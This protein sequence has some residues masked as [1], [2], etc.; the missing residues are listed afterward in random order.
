MI[1]SRI[2]IYVVST[3]KEW[4][5]NRSSVIFFLLTHSSTQWRKSS[6]SSLHVSFV[7]GLLLTLS[8]H[9]CKRCLS[10]SHAWSSAHNSFNFVNGSY[11]NREKQDHKLF[12]FPII[13][14]TYSITNS[15]HLFFD[16]TLIIVMFMSTNTHDN[17]AK[18]FSP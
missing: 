13:L 18:T 12:F 3:K 7:H 15:L 6:N 16:M 14:L 10:A 5:E 4:N 17:R 8:V 9:S 1:I 11:S 2:W